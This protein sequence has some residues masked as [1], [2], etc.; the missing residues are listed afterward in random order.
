MVWNFVPNEVSALGTLGHGLSGTPFT[1][2]VG[3]ALVM[4]RDGI[5]NDFFVS[6]AGANNATGSNTPVM[7][8]AA[9][10]NTASPTSIYGPMGDVPFFV[11]DNLITT[12]AEALSEAQYDLGVSI[13]SAWTLAVTSPPNPLFDIDDVCTDT[14]PYLGLNLVKFILNSITT[15]IRYDAQTVVSGRVI[16]SGS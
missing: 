16:P 11:Y 13:A 12:A 14:D 2:P 5:Y 3:T 1:T 8:E 6:A 4:T 9:D 15:S 7:A 10:T